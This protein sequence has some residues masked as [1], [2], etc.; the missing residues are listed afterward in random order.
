MVGKGENS[1]GAALFD[2]RLFEA[3]DEV[4]VSLVHTIKHANRND[5]RICE[6]QGGQLFQ[7]A[8]R[9]VKPDAVELLT[10]MRANPSTPVNN[11]SMESNFTASRHDFRASVSS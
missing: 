2:S 9:L 6:M 10:D 8:H 3:T 11:G 5:G 1:A 7:Y 4:M